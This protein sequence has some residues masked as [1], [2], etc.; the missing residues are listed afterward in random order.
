MPLDVGQE[1]LLPVKFISREIRL[2]PVRELTTV[3]YTSKRQRFDLRSV[4]SLQPLSV[5]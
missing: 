5:S 2:R 4:E 3:L 1:G